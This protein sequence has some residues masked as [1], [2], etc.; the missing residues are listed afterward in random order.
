MNDPNR[1][2][3]LEERDIQAVVRVCNAA[4]E[5]SEST[6]GPD[7]VDARQIHAQLFVVRQGKTNWE[8]RPEGRQRAGEPG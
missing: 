8:N 5:R 7:L 2:R 6:Y 3:R 1:I 4:I